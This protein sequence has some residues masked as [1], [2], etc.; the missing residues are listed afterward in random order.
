MDTVPIEKRIALAIKRLLS[1]LVSRLRLLLGKVLHLALHDQ[2]GEISR[3]TQRLGSASVESVNYLGSE[4][5]AMNERLAKIE[6]QLAAV[7]EQLEA[8]RSSE[9]V[10]EE[11]EDVASGPRSR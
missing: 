7:R 1:V 4:L 3:Q 10:V 8:S 2:L 6:E 5:L 11:G 9:S